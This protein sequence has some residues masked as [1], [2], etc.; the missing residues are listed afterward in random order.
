MRRTGKQLSLATEAMQ[1]VHGLAQRGALPDRVGRELAAEIAGWIEAER[2]GAE[3]AVEMLNDQLAAA[4]EDTTA[5]VGNLDREDAA[6][7]RAG[8]RVIAC[9][10]A[11]R[12]ATRA[13]LARF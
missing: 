10:E 5:E 2:E 9:L 4:V 7:I 1:L 11:A 6:G 13:A 8:Q 12:D 3:E